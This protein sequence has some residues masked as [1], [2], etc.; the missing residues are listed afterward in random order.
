MSDE[1]R[2][3]I[4]YA[5]TGVDLDAR[6][7]IAKR[8]GAISKTTHG[9]QVLGRSGGFAGLFHLGGRFRDPVLVA[10]TDGVGT[11]VLLHAAFDTIRLAGHDIVNNNVNDLI[12]VGA[13]PLFFLDYIATNGLATEQRIA[14]VEGIAEACRQNGIALIGG[15]T[16]DMP[17]VYRPGDFD[18]AGFVVGAME[19][20]GGIDGSTIAAGDAL[21]A[22][23][24]NGLMTNGYSLV[25]EAWGLGKGLG[26]E[27]DRRILDERHEEL[28]GTLG[29]ALTAPHP[30]FWP[31]LQPILPYLKGV[32]HITGGGIPGNLPRVLPDEVAGVIEAAS[33][34]V[35]PLFEL[36][37][38]TGN[39]DAAEMFRTFN[40]GVGMILAV[41]EADAQAVLDATPG[42]WRIGSVERRGDGGAVRGLPLR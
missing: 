8:F 20:D 29:A 35:P 1:Q 28:R 3:A 38:R 34:T 7:A 6:E 10:T 42:S 37:R 26:V 15:E 23:P 32:A 9:P 40:M 30:P 24:S 19:R 12:T 36:I 25:R 27:H 22:L 5:G 39:V 13:E 21:I 11:K 17:D 33:W 4:T 2:P 31:Q 41:A 16:A 18:L 14:L